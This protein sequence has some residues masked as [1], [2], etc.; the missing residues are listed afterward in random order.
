M[1]YT[2]IN[3]TS[4]DIRTP[5]NIIDVLERVR[6]NRTRIRVYYGDPETGKDWNEVFGIFGYVGRSMGSIKIPLLVHN[7]RSFGGPP[8]STHCLVKIETS[9]G[10]RILYEHPTYHKD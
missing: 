7:S 9:K 1:E 2:E 10:K 5:K 6:L 3:G 8:L 4:Y